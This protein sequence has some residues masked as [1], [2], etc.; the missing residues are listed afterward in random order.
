MKHLY[1][2]VA[3][4]IAHHSI[5]GCNMSAGDMLGS[6]T[7]SRTVKSGYG[8]MVELCWGDTEPIMLPNG[9]VRKI[10]VYGDEVNLTAHTTS[11]SSFTIEFG[12]YRGQI[13]PTKGD[14]ENFRKS[15]T[16]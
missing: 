11:P 5:T 8:S 1:Y 7:I 12:D 15:F 6:R 13:L 3:Q 10:L 2:S 14:E 9:E 4:T 16:E